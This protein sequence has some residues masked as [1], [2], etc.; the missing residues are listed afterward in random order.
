MNTYKVI[1]TQHKNPNL[2]E[3]LILYVSLEITLY[4]S[5]S[6]KDIINY[7]GKNYPQYHYQIQELDVIEL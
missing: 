2:V 3:E 1:L 7:V 5:K 4:N 6:H